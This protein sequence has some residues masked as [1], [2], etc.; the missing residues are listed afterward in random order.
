MGKTVLNKRSVVVEHEQPKLPTPSQ[1][2]YG[3]IAINYADGY[4][5]LSIKN[6]V[7]DIVPF[8][9][10]E[11][12]EGRIDEAVS[13]RVSA[14]TLNGSSVTISGGVA[15]LGNLM[16][17]DEEYVIADSLN[18]LNDRI[19]ELSAVS[20]TFLTTEQ[21]EAQITAHTS[22]IESEIA[23]IT[24]TCETFVTSGDVETQITAHTAPIYQ[25]LDTK[26]SGITMNGSALTV[27]GGVADLGRV[28][29]SNE[30]YVIAQSLND[31]NG[32]INALSA[33][34]EDF[35][36]S[37]QVDAQITGYT[38]VIESEITAITAYTSTN[39]YTKTEVDNLLSNAGVTRVTS[40][41]Y[42]TMYN[43][44]TLDANT[45]YAIV[46]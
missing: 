42:Q 46:D 24:S 9:S 23:D 40:A 11:I 8:S 32:R 34:S 35:L 20:E 5:T 30:E 22:V 29:G 1:L 33:T 16:G 44:G 18:D 3:E 12:I 37:E 17:E 28:L 4:E 19:L 26:V 27:S 25:V 45:L 7:N 6:N 39:Y 43:N 36:T 15:D 38:S 2:Q 13:N 21:V 31:L 10:D 14:I 41:Q